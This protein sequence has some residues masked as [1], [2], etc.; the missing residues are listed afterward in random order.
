MSREQQLAR[1]FVGLTDTLADDF[2]PLGL[3]QRLVA[4]CV[5]LLEVDAAAVMMADARGGLRTLAASDEEA[6]FLELLQVQTGAGPCMD[7]Y[8]SGD[9]FGVADFASQEERWPKLVPRALEA[10]YRSIHTVPLRVRERVIG[11]VNLFRTRTGLLSRDDAELAQALADVAAL[12][13]MH[14]SNEPT[15]GEDVITRAQSTIAAKATLE[16]AKGM[17]A[18]Y[19][20]VSIAGAAALLH[21]YAGRHGARLSDT[22][23]ALTS[24]ALDPGAVMENRALRPGRPPEGGSGRLE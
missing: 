19:A 8:R 12:A 4:D 16:M 11:A 20:D 10:G 18:K 21:A 22:A 15:R 6:A 14:W 3:F 17:I 9:A 24:R 2:D 5:T 13:L 1:A 23:Q 7:C